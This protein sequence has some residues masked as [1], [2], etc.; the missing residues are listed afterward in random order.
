MVFG[1]SSFSSLSVFVFTYYTLVPFALETTITT[2]AAVRKIQCYSNPMS[3][4]TL[5]YASGSAS[6]RRSGIPPT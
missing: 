4:G 2:D 1:M 3:G 5:R 6:H